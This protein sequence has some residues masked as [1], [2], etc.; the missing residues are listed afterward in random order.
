MSDE[1]GAPVAARGGRNYGGKYVDDAG[2]ERDRWDRPLLPHPKTGEVQPWT[3]PSTL[4][5]TLDDPFHL[6]QWKLRQVVHGL[7]KRSDLYA[8]ASSIPNDAESK[9]TLQGIASSAMEAAESSRGANLGTALHK[10]TER[11]DLEPTVAT[12]ALAPAELSADLKA[13]VDTMRHYGLIRDPRYVER[14][15][16]CTSLQAAGTPDRFVECSDGMWRVADLKTGQWGAEYGALEYAIQ[17]GTYAN[18]D[19][20]WNVE[21]Q[22][23]EPMP[24]PLDTSYGIVIH[25]PSGQA[26]CDLYAIN[27]VEGLGLAQLAVTVRDVRKRQRELAAP[28]V[29]ATSQEYRVTDAEREQWKAHDAAAHEKKLQ[30]VILQAINTAS[31]RDEL[32][33]LAEVHADGGHWTPE[34]QAAAALR[35]GQLTC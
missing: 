12:T 6:E 25:L 11:I 18:G 22:V 29:V 32:R 33:R 26:K 28:L 10:W 30:G 13:Y 19:A 20:V 31:K 1:F 34:H 8:L 24:A 2:I 16:C 5:R 9:K 17:L 14:L 21:D 4:S 27:L 3:R 23:W 7:G 15:V 35:W